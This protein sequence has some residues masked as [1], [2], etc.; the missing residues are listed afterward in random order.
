MQLVS[1]E[2]RCIIISY[3]EIAIYLPVKEKYVNI[4]YIKDYIK[5]IEPHVDIINTMT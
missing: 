1:P 2:A 3:C 5:Y 4:N